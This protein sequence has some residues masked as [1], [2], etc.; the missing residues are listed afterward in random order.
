MNFNKKYLNR[1][2]LD[3]PPKT[4]LQGLTQLVQQHLRQIP[5]E[6]LDIHLKN[7]ILLELE[8]LS[9]KIIDGNRGGFCYELNGLFHHLLE[10]LG[11]NATLISA[12]VYE[13]DGTYS[14]EFDHAAVLVE[15]E[16]RTYLVDVG[17]GD[18]TTIPLAIDTIE[19]QHDKLHPYQ[20]RHM[21]SQYTV[22]IIKSHETTPMYKFRKTPRSLEEF[23][24]RC[25]FHQEDPKSHFHRKK[26]ITKM[27]T[28]G[29][30]TLTSDHLIVHEHERKCKEPVSGL[31]FDQYL[32][33]YFKIA[34]P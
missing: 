27:T 5:F 18:F 20:I 34:M 24:E 33:R 21:D 22:S 3:Y 10:A 14:P 28:S 13:K 19:M 4:D 9:L 25:Q 12:Q 7:P 30:I 2:Q 31:Q 15:L 26:M 6:N 23:K 17:F 11:Y 1:L 16:G 29:R 32:Y 8:K